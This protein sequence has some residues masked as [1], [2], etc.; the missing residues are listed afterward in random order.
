[1]TEN[2]ARA[3][4]GSNV[5]EIRE[6]E[7]RVREFMSETGLDAV[8]LRRR[9]N[10]SWLT[11]G[12]YNYVGMGTDLGVASALITQNDKFIISTNIEARRIAE[13]EVAGQG[14]TIRDYPWH[15]GEDRERLIREL[16]GSSRCAADDG[17]PGLAPLPPSFT[18]LR[19]SLTDA[20]VARYR[21]LGAECGEAIA[22][23][24]RAVVP[25]ETEAAI[26]GRMAKSCFDRGV[27]PAV[28]LI[29]ADERIEKHRHP[30]FTNKRVKRCAMVVLCG[31]KRGLICSVTR[32]VHFGSLGESLA[33]KHEAA[34]LIDATLIAATRVGAAVGEI[35]RSGIA[36]YE[37][38]G[39]GDEWKLHHQGGPCGYAP[40][41]YLATPEEKRIVLPNQAFAWNPSI[42]GTKSE[43][44]II[45]LPNGPLVLSLAEGWPTVEVRIGNRVI[46]RADILV[47]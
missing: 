5:K 24:A 1:M 13:E 46:Q 14:F 3:W 36:L 27:L 26:A 44:T 18:G 20:E 39:F 11:D 9:D 15:R 16:A 34:T 43:D 30:I 2:A 22:N 38:N 31:Q 47:K 23:V 6:K 45:A 35:L 32:L 33:R 42:T 19:Y 8:L 29:A 17:T 37:K 10:F 40:R 41:D 4:E 25:G 7:R 28:I 12:G 21:A